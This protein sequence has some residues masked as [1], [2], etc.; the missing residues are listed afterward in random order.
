MQM[1]KQS[2]SIKQ[3][4]TTSGSNFLA[5]FETINQSTHDQDSTGNQ[6]QTNIQH[7]EATP[8]TSTGPGLSQFSSS[9]SNFAEVT[10]DSTQSGKDALNETQTAEQFAGNSGTIPGNGIDQSAPLG[11]NTA[12]L[13]HIQQQQLDNSASQTQT[14]TQDGDI[15]QNGSLG[16]NFASGTQFQDQQEHGGGVQRQSGGPRC[17]SLQNGGQFFV[18]I[19]TNQQADHISPRNQSE[20]IE[21]NCD[22]NPGGTCHMNLSATQQNVTTGPTPP[23][24]ETPSFCHQTIFLGSV[25]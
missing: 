5:V 21:G 2:V 3:T 13:S 20:F 12:A 18:T 24:C 16:T 14:A 1:A 22:S 6:T 11:K 8:F 15:T 19:K 7:V 10:Q 25:G 4:S 23:T 9:G 17:C